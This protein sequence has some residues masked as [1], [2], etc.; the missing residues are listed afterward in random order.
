[1]ITVRPDVTDRERRAW[2][3]LLFDLQRVRF[4]GGSLEIRLYTAGRNH[5]RRGDR[6]AGNNVDARKRDLLEGQTVLNGPFWSRR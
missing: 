1:M 5:S 6:S 2:G 3:D 4:H